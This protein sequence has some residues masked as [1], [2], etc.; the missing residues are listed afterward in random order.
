MRSHTWLAAL[1]ILVL[2][3]GLFA[4]NAAQT[5]DITGV[6][7]A[8]G[9][10]ATIFEKGDPL[11][12]DWAK[13]K[14]ATAK[15]SF[16]PKSVTLAETNDPVYKC[17]PPGVPRVY[18]HPFPMQIIQ[19]PKMLLMF[20]E[21]DHTMRRIYMDGRKHN[22]DI[23]A[24]W[25]GDSLGKWEGDTLVV[26]TTGLNDKSW[27]DRLGHPHSDQMRVTEKMKKTAADNL[28]IE[29]TIEDAKAYKQPFSVTFNM[30]GMPKWE[31]A[32][33]NCVDN[34]NLENLEPTGTK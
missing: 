19:A 26:E 7:T 34:V 23:E 13:A 25:M 14:Y 2:P 18:F 32:E 6:W 31:I 29:V 8:R 27:V 4:Q 16:G 21:Y 24:T 33:Q 30:R 28:Q 9:L 1:G 10:S 15:P 11:M 17:F 12:T 3:L 22:E 5:P 20:F